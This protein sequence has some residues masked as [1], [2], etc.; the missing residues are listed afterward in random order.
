LTDV[1]DYPARLEID[2]P[3]QLNRRL[4]LIN[5]CSTSRIT[6]W[7]APWSARVIQGSSMDGSRLVAY[8]TPSLIGARVLIAAIA[9]LFT[10]R[11]PTGSTIR[12]R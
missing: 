2:Y 10:G 3:Q 9:L 7:L 12:L 1:R 6:S 4:P 11:Y 5:G 8:S